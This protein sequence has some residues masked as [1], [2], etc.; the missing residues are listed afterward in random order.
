VGRFVVHE[1]VKEQ[2]DFMTIEEQARALAYRPQARTPDL[3][4]GPP[5]DTAVLNRLRMGKAAGSHCRFPISWRHFDAG[6]STVRAPLGFD[7]RS[8]GAI[9]RI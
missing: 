1:I 9:L 4:K 8:R 2:V 5:L 7:D 6:E 3:I